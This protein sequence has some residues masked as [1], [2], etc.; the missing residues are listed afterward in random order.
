MAN[1]FYYIRQKKKGFFT[2]KTS[3]DQEYKN[4]LMTSNLSG[5][6]HQCKENLN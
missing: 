6:D 4:S 1:Q 5:E 3:D 2:L